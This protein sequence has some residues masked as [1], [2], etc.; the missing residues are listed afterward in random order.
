[1]YTPSRIVIHPTAAGNKYTSDVLRRVKSLNPGVEIEKLPS[2]RQLPPQYHDLHKQLSYLKETILLR[3][4]SGP[5]ITTFASP[6]DIVEEMSTIV[7]LGWHCCC[8]CEYCY[9]QASTRQNPWQIIYTNIEKLD[10]EFAV[11]PWVHRILLTLLSAKSHIDQKPQMKVPDGFHVVANRIRRQIQ[12]S[13][14]NRITDDRAALQYLDGNLFKFLN[15]LN[16]YST[17]R[18][19]HEF[20]AEAS[21]IAK[22]SS[23]DPL[24]NLVEE[25]RRSGYGMDYNSVRSTFRII[26]RGSHKV[27]GR[28]LN[29]LQEILATDPDDY[30]DGLF[31]H[32][33]QNLSEYYQQNSIYKPRLNIS[34][35]SDAVAIQHISKHLDRVMDIASKHPGIEV[36]LPTK[37]TNLD[38][39]LNHDGAGRTIVT[40]NF[41][42]DYFIQTFEH[43]TASLADRFAAAQKIQAA[44]GF[45]LNVSIEPMF[46]Y[47][48]YLTDYKHLVGQIMS[49]IDPG[50]VETVILGSARFGKTLKR[51]LLNIHPK[52][53][54][55]Q[56]NLPLYPIKGEDTK[57]RNADADR[58]AAYKAMICEFRKYGDFHFF[59]GAETPEMWEAVGLDAR[60]H[61]DNF[62]YQYLNQL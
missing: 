49:E 14:S 56:K 2:A 62:V 5:F 31:T 58:K 43:G 28:S 23:C 34:E 47:R 41:N 48:N 42:T 19:L 59:L 37:S 45:R 4:R 1:M 54:V 36:I 10:Q 32:I 22:K 30:S 29:K 18:L 44:S 11:E 12:T 6:G 7:S 39:L 26:S 51:I 25:I 27:P 8:D 21:K 57:W 24:T 55:F 46:F 53:E 38:E 52:T 13:K 9:L 15:E 60:A 3:E 16:P 20:A 40:V 17:Y 35:Y 50:K 33:Q 61:L